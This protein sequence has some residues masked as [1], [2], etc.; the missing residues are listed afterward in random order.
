MTH[1]AL[2]NAALFWFLAALTLLLVLCI[3]AVILA[4]A[5]R[6]ASAAPGE[7]RAAAPP[8]PPSRQ[9]P[10][11]PSPPLPPTQPPAATPTASVHAASIVGFHLAPAAGVNGWPAADDETT[12]LSAVQPRQERIERIERAK[13][14]GGPAVGTGT[15]ATRRRQLDSG[16]L[17]FSKLWPA[18]TPRKRATTCCGR[19]PSPGAGDFGLGRAQGLRRLVHTSAQLLARRLS[20]LASDLRK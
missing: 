2:V 7:H 19:S 6:P 12:G 5:Q 14:S 3:T 17:G 11:A 15:Q 20:R 8:P 10:A 13:V 16:R 4:P 1:A 18:S 9:P